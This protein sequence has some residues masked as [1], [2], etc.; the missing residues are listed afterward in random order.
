MGNVFSVGRGAR[1]ESRDIPLQSKLSFDMWNWGVQQRRQQTTFASSPSLLAILKKVLYGLAFL[2]PGLMAMAGLFTG[3][4]NVGS[5][6]RIFVGGIFGPAFLV[7]GVRFEWK[8]YKAFRRWKTFDA[9]S[10]QLETAPVPLGTTLRGEVQVPVAPD[11]PPEEGFQV[12]VTAYYKSGQSKDKTWE[13]STRVSGEPG[14]DG[15]IVS[16]SLDLPVRPLSDLQKRGPFSLDM[17]SLEKFDWTLTVTA[18]FEDKADYKA[19]FD[20]PVSVPDDL[21]EQAGEDPP[22]DHAPPDTP[23]GTGDEAF[24]D[25][26]G[27]EAGL[28]RAADGTGADETGNGKT[29][30]E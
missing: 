24:W 17:D 23:T 25:V 1:Q 26:G 15:T 18:S 29:D 13:G 6:G 27:E 4:Q 9:S 10:L 5:F 8:A 20:L 16:F 12:C 19:S 28:R 7:L 14:G 30:A 2:G 11:D 22:E 3:G 21:G